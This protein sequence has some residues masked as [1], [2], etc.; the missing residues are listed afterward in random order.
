[1]RSHD[2]QY[3][4]LVH[5]F[6]ILFL[7][8][9]GTVMQIEKA[10]IKDPLCVLKVSWNFRILAISNFAVIYPLNILFS[11][12]AA[13]FLTLSRPKPISYR[14]QSIDLLWYRPR[15]WKG[16]TVSIVFLLINKTLRLY[17]FKIKTATNAKISVF[18][19]YVE[20]IIYLLLYNLHGCTY[21]EMQ[22]MRTS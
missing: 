14:N 18:V 1:M 21:T 9:K 15:T 3:L 17:N 7:L 16:L 8:H 4:E 2:V 22:N 20:A 10:L 11:L 5:S 13:Y 12:K 19:I 6:L